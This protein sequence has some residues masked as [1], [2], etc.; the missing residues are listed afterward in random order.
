MSV[1]FIVPLH[2][3]AILFYVHVHVPCFFPDHVNFHFSAH[4]HVHQYMYV[5]V[6]MYLYLYMYLCNYINVQLQ[7][8]VGKV[9]FKN[10]GDEALSDD[11]R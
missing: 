3:Q 9:T 8:E 10:N 4:V 6:L 2:F 1:T 11:S 5:Y 7:A